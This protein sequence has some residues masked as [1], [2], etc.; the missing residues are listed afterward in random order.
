M[1]RR[2]HHAFF[3][4]HEQLTRSPSRSCEENPLP[5]VV[6]RDQWLNILSKKIL[7]DGF[8]SRSAQKLYTCFDQK[9]GNRVP[10]VVIV[11]S[12]RCLLQT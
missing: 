1:S 4:M 11:A 9:N 5:A 7:D 8:D 12:I 10:W 3:L 2:R 6:S